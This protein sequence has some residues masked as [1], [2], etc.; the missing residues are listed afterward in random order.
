MC[1][2]A[3]PVENGWEISS[4]RVAFCLCRP[5]QVAVGVDLFAVAAPAAHVAHVA[6]LVRM[7]LS[8]DYDKN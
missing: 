3:P 6:G 2:R 4:Q 8:E 1:A 5:H 7:P